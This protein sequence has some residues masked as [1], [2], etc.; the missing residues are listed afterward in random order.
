LGLLGGVLVAIVVVAFYWIRYIRAH[1]L[2]AKYHPDN[3][4]PKE[5][6]GG[7][8]DKDNKPL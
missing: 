2:K 4:S 7:K 5:V 6:W 3:V 8:T 1:S